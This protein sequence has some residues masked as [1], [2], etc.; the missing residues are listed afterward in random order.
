MYK[1]NAAAV[2][3]GNEVSSWFRINSGVKQDFV[4]SSFIWIILMDFVLRST[5]KSME[6]HGIK[7][8]GKTFLDLDYADDLSISVERVSK[9]N[10][11]LEVLRVHGVEIGSRTDVRKTKSLRLGISEEDLNRLGWRRV[12]LALLAPGG[13]VTW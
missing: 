9:M 1:N 4:L 11:L 2:K 8:G 12:C 6:E 5:R 7:W 13:L 10:E 3:V